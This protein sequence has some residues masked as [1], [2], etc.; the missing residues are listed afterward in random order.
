MGNDMVEKIF[1]YSR[2][3]IL[4][5]DMS[6][7]IPERF[8][9]AFR[10]HCEEYFRASRSRP[11]GLAI[12]SCGQHRD[13]RE[14]PA[15]ITLSY[16]ETQTGPCAIALVADLTEEKP[17]QAALRPAEEHL[18]LAEEAV[19]IGI[20]D[21]S[22]ETGETI[23]N[24]EW[25]PLYG[26]PPV[27]RA[28][29]REAWLALIHPDDRQRI[30]REL[31][32][33]LATTQPYET[34]FRVVWPDGSTHWLLG[35]ARAYRDAHGV[36][37]RMLGVNID[38]TARKLAEESLHQSEERFARF[39]AH[40]PASTFIKD[41]TGHYVYANPWFEKVSGA[42]TNE[43]LG[44]TDWG[45]WPELA[46]DIT[47]QDRQVLETGVATTLEFIRHLEGKEHYYQAIKFPIPDRK[48]GIAFVGVIS[49]EVTERVLLDQERRKLLKTLTT[50]Q[51]EERRRVSREIHDN[52]TQNLGG[53]AIDLGRL[54]AQPP[55][56]ARGLKRLFQ[57]LQRRVIAAAEV[58]RHIAHQLHPSELDDLGLA[59]ALR[60][61]CEDFAQRE[62]LTI[63]FVEHDLPPVLPKEIASCLY[64]LTQEGLR[65][66]VKHAKAPTAEVAVTGSGKRIR[67]TLKDKGVGFKPSLLGHTMGLG[68]QSMRERVRLLDGTFSVTSQP[69]DGTEIV[70]EVPL[71]EME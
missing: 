35:K 27:D 43:W 60:S 62:S 2:E 29:Q 49:F 46:A 50:A 20:W 8:R 6:V 39:M 9:A 10:A 63:D 17:A 19:G 13:G 59:A 14:F 69:G 7:L 16:A 12:H 57:E 71:P 70:A 55:Q 56:S 25:G 26:L 32:Q 11:P 67:L 52:L 51:E 36:M 65:N 68:I 23:C 5:R 45:L 48:G 64:R 44:A 30:D 66:V 40:I 34:E 33:A 47:A 18:A 54:A 31:D 24:R 61:F 21:W 22:V 42:A 41:V 37:R 28:L 53:M 4:G 58:T 1:G 38:I 15:D 3:A